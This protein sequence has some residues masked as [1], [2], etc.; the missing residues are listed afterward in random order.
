MLVLLLPCKLTV[1]R[2]AATEFFYCAAALCLS[3]SVDDVYLERILMKRLT[4]LPSGFAFAINRSRRIQP[5]LVGLLYNAHFSFTFIIRER[6]REFCITMIISPTNQ[7]ILEWQCFSGST[8][9]LTM[10]ISRAT[11][12]VLQ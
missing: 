8:N 1:A 7:L 10:H 4:R 3:L 12:N 9:A 11:T 6:E 2:V 5:R